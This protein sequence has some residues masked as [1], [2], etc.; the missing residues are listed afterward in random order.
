MIPI[1]ISKSIILA[2]FLTFLIAGS[3]Y[4]GPH[5]IVVVQSGGPSASEQAQQQIDRLA[6]QIAATAGWDV[7]TVSG[8]YFDNNMEAAEYVKKNKPAFVLGD[9]GFYLEFRDQLDLK[10]F[11]Q[12]TLRGKNDVT[13]Y[14]VA[15]KNS[16]K[17]LDDLKGKTLCGTHLEN[18]KYIERIVFEG[19]ISLGDDVK[20]TKQRSLRSLRKLAKGE[21]DAVLLD[22]KEHSSLKSGGLPFEAD[23]VTIFT[24][25]PVPNNGFMTVGNTASSEDIKAFTEAA[26]NFCE[27]QDAKE[28]CKDFDIQGFKPIN[29]SFFSEIRNQY[30]GK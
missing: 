1:R 10:V 18:P 19:A 8:K 12:A 21:A 23:F 9:L 28:I 17:S 13:F 15:Q 29:D 26:K 27:Y 4:A 24:S 22:E 30:K 20:V 11:N 16:F 2:L 14:V 25:K 5:D 6:K 7:N 3:V